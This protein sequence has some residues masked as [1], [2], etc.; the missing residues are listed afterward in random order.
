MGNHCA[1]IEVGWGDEEILSSRV[2]RYFVRDGGAGTRGVH[3]N[4]K[5]NHEC[6]I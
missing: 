3:N 5:T 1:K 4:N 6:K 2:I